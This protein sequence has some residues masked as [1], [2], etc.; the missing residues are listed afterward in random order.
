[1]TQT[2]TIDLTNKQMLEQY[3]KEEKRY[4]D[5]NFVIYEDN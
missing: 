1:M 3:E 5:I 4:N 2:R